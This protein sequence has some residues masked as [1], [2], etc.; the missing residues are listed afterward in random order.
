[1]KLEWSKQ[2]GQYENGENLRLGRL[3]VASAHYSSLRSKGDPEAWEANCTLPGM[4]QLASAK[5]FLTIEEAKA[6]AEALVREWVRMAGLKE[7]DK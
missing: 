7:D 4:R 5:R 1:M 2:T 3:F 6:H